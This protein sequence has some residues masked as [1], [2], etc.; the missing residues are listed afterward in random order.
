ML[1]M[2]N[3]ISLRNNVWILVP[4]P[5]HI[6]VIGIKWILKNKNDESGT[7][8]RNKARLVAQGYSHIQGIYFD[9]TFAHVARIKSI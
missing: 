7:V 8:I 6:I 1:C 5:S 3:Y 4:I 9:E 2:R